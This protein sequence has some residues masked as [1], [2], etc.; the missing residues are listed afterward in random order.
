MPETGIGFF[1]D[2][3]SSHF[4]PRLQG[5]LGIFLA[6]TGTR[7]AGR[8]IFEAGI[9]THFV[10]SANLSQIEEDVMRLEK[11]DI[12]SIDRILSK[13]QE[14]WEVD[15]KKEFSL[16]PYIGKINSAFSADSVEGIIDNL[17][18]DNSEWA[19][20]Q[21][22][23]LERMSPTSL[24]VTF[25]MMRR[26]QGLTLPECLK[27]EYRISQRMMENDDFF[28]GVKARECSFFWIIYFH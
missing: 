5:R 13:Y 2:V 28:T 17:K 16:K 9:A 4:M 21:V 27:M 11:P 14:Q 12:V 7:L 26:G 1:P 8:D 22:A 25:E 19:K 20:K 15:F 3:G 6:L 10:P 18:K 24:K 23:L